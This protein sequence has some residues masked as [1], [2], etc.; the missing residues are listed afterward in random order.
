MTTSLRDDWEPGAIARIVDRAE[1]LDDWTRLR[2]VALDD[3]EVW[4]RLALALQDAAGVRSVLAAALDSA[5]CVPLP[6]AASRRARASTWCAAAAAAAVLAW[7]TLRWRS[8]T[9]PP[10]P[11]ASASTTVEEL[12]SLLLETRPTADGRATEVI[13][14]RRTVERAPIESFLGLAYD[15]YGDPRPAVVDAAELQLPRRF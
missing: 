4:E 11:P 8:E 7:A 12:P 6:A 1:T 3:G 2:A 14:L 9:P 10:P 5:E 13:F 15:E